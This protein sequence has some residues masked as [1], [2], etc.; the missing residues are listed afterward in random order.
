VGDDHVKWGKIL[1]KKGGGREARVITTQSALSRI[2]IFR[3]VTEEGDLLRR[4]TCEI[5]GWMKN[6][7]R[8]RKGAI[9]WK[10]LRR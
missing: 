2:S 7:H 1:E 3:N 10:G 5:S 4:G 8:Y 6:L 9:P